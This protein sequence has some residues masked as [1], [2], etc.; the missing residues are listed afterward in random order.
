MSEGRA[1][2][3]HKLYYEIHGAKDAPKKVVFVMGLQTSCFGWSVHALVISRSEAE[4]RD[5]NNQ[6]NYLGKLPG[7]GVLVFDNRGVG[8]SESVRPPNGERS[9]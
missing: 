3:T 6:V 7:Y 4:S 8:N 5:R 9:Y 2:E 1:P